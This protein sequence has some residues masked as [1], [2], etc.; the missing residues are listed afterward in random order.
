M[1]Q[2]ILVFLLTAEITLGA[3]AQNRSIVF[4]NTTVWNK[5]VKT[6]KKEKKL[7]FVDC[8]TSWCAPCKVLAAKVF[9]QDSVADFF[10]ANFVNAKLD[11]EK[12]VDGVK[13]AKQ[14]EVHAYPTMLFIDPNTGE[15]VHK[16]VG[17]GTPQWLIAEGEKAIDPLNN[18]A[19]LEKRYANGERDAD[20]IHLYLKALGSSYQT[21]KRSKVAVNYLDSLPPEELISKDNW[22]LISAN[23]TD[24]LSNPLKTV[25]ANRR[26][27]YE[28][29]GREVVDYVLEKNLVGATTILMVEDKYDATRASELKSYL[30]SVDFEAVPI[31]LSYLYSAEA[32]YKGDY[33]ALLANVDNA[34]KYGIFNNSAAGNLFFQNNIEKLANS[35]DKALVAEGVKRIDDRI[36]QTSNYFT[37]ANLAN[38]KYRILTAI[39]DTLGADKAKMEEEKYSKTGENESGGRMVRAIR[40]N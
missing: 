14:H 2:L 15:A 34:F 25:M 3:N 21:E 5:I 31:A 37:K 40:M 36:A 23:I 35:S 38:S 9:T 24:P 7:I 6:A 13:L 20:F 32:L 26:K 30:L 18:L 17:S 29:A 22:D 12:D 1:K 11:M 28:L 4:E 27:F 33:Q 16:I 39:G 10:N 8:Y 19:A